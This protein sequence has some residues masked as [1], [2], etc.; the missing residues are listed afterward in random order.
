M[1]TEN[2]D[3]SICEVLSFSI[4]ATIPGN[5]VTISNL[6]TRR[7]T[8]CFHEFMSPLKSHLVMRR[9]PVQGVPWAPPEA[10]GMDDPK[11][12]KKRGFCASRIN[13]NVLASQSREQPE[14][15]DS[16]VECSRGWVQGM[17]KVDIPVIRIGGSPGNQTP[18][19][20]NGRIPFAGRFDNH[21][22][23]PRCNAIPGK[24]RKC[25]SQHC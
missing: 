12:K 17:S 21:C 22:I 3:Q 19:K 24:V 4:P 10:E 2:D 1:G 15:D 9:R 7:E 23:S 5:P 18:R 13:G 11:N 14:K 20:K 25:Q 16:K 8:V 6:S